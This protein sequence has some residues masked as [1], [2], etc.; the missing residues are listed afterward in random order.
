MRRRDVRD[1]CPGIFN[2]R[3]RRDKSDLRVRRESVG[4]EDEEQTEQGD[5]RHKIATFTQPATWSFT[6]YGA[7][8]SFRVAR[9]SR[10]L[11]KASRLRELSRRDVSDFGHLIRGDA[12]G[13]FVLARRQN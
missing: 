2:A 5:H 7:V 10:T 4:E 13:K 1:R 3:K 6:I 11:A 8:R 9:S 12:S